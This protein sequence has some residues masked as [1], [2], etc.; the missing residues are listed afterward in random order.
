MLHF[1]SQSPT[2]IFNFLSFAVG[3]ENDKMADKLIEAVN[4]AAIKHKNQRRK[5]ED[6]TPYINHPIGVA[7]ILSNEAEI[8]DIQVLIAAMLHDTVEDTNTTF[9]EIEN[10]F[11]KEVR[12]I[13]NE[14]SDDK[15]LP[16]EER[17]RLQVE[18]ASSHSYKA[19]L[20]KLADKIY[21]L[22]DLNRST[23]VG[24][25]EQRVEEYFLWASRVFQGL[26]GTNSKLDKI[27]IEL[28]KERNLMMD[29]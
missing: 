2:R 8:D 28:L 14:C 3:I 20:V 25:S 13:V 21:N 17:K 12:D 5:D 16:K 18:H 1:V 24:W 15:S 27:Y 29:C 4:F 10:I 9:D 7:F 19:K 22:R 23:P 11:G 6:K 26:R